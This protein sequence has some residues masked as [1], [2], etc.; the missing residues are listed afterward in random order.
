MKTAYLFHDA[1]SNPRE[2]W[3]PWLKQTLAGLGYNVIIPELPTPAGQT[4]TAWRSAIKNFIPT[5]DTDTILIGHGAGGIFALHLI[6]DMESAKQ[7]R[8]LFIVSGYAERVGHAGFDRV[9]ET[10]LQT[11]FKWETIASRVMSIHVFTGSDDPFIPIQASERLAKNLGVDLEIIQGGGHINHAS[12]FSQFVQLAASIRETSGMIEKGISLDSE[13]ISTTPIASA[14]PNNVAPVAGLEF[15]PQRQEIPADGKEDVSAQTS[16]VKQEIRQTTSRDSIPHPP[17]LNTTVPQP[18]QPKNPAIH[19]M[20]QDMGTLVDSNRGSVAS[21]LLGKAREEKQEKRERSAGSPKNMLYVVGSLLIIIAAIAVIGYVVFKYMPAQKNAKA[22][23]IASLI[24]SDR[25]VKIDISAGE[26]YTVISAIKTAVIPSVQGGITDIYYIKGLLRASFPEV[27]EKINI[28]TVPESLI[29][30]FPGAYGTTPTFMHGT[31]TARGTTGHFLVLPITHYDIAFAGMRDWEPTLFRDLGLFMNVPET[32]LKTKLAKDSFQDEMIANRTVRALRF[33]KT[34]DIS[35]DENSKP[36]ADSETEGITF[37][38]PLDESETTVTT[39][40]FNNII[41]P[42]IN[43]ISPYDENELMIGYFFLTE[44]SVVIT[45]NLELIPE[46][47]A[48][49]ANSQIYR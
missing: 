7:I 14:M 29:Q 9:N 3:Y 28:T 11:N 10:F 31:V 15:V 47:L 39:P 13:K 21:S 4:L 1:F 44:N 43:P 37:T 41:N 6:E 45:D 25:H 22:P 34:N 33:Q 42:F 30:E 24:K 16:S 19:T 32:F 17:R 20:Y 18:P 5:F 26:Y 46:I 12:G 40:T 8:G 35:L 48:R 36:T 2:D 23:E 49:F 27:L 38:I